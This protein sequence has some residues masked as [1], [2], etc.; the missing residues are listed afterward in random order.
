MAAAAIRV[1]RASVSRLAV[2]MA[3]S[4]TCSAVSGRASCSRLAKPFSTKAATSALRTCCK[5]F[6]DVC[7]PGRPEPVTLPS[8]RAV[9][10][11]ECV[12]W[13]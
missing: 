2:A 10:R 9:S 1:S 7:I 3:L 13:A 6:L 4:T 11:L 8:R 12:T 5:S